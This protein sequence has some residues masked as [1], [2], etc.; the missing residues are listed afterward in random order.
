MLIF[1]FSYFY[2]ADRLSADHRTSRML[3]AMATL[4]AS[5][6]MLATRLGVF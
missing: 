3:T 2:S 1:W 6:K 4:A 5:I